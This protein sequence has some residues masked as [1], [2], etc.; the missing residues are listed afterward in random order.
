MPIKARSLKSKILDTGKKAGILV[1]PDSKLDTFLTR[2]TKTAATLVNDGEKQAKA[3]ATE[4]R[5]IVENLKAK[6]H[7]AT[8]PTPAPKAAAKPAPKAA[9]KPAAKKKK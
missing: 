4:A 2:G 7:E 3:F 9:A 6:L 5:S 1:A 8:A